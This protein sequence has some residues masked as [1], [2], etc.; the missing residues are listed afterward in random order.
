MSCSAG[1]PNF[2]L[3]DPN[4]GWDALDPNSSN[5]LGFGDPGGIYLA[6]TVAGAVDPTQLFQYLLPARLAR[7]CAACE[8]YL[9]TPFP[10]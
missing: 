9:L 2:R 7:G 10:P 1:K 4:V 8:W 3:L 6:Q 5:L